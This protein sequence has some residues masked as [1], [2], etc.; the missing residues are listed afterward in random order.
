MGGLENC[1]TPTD[2]TASAKSV[3]AQ[4]H[5][6]TRARAPHAHAHTYHSLCPHGP[7]HLTISPC[8]Y[9]AAPLPVYKLKK[10]EARF[11]ISTLLEP[12][13]DRPSVNAK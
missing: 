11:S 5:V 7:L 9:P 8:F 6:H 1:R 13:V 2:V 4:M 10:K 12:G 3:S